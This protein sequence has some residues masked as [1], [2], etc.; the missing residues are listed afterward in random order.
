[1]DLVAATA[2]TYPTIPPS[3]A[4]SAFTVKGVEATFN[5]FL[6]HK[7]A[8]GALQLVDRFSSILAMLSMREEAL[9]KTILAVGLTTLGKGPNDQ[10]L[11]RQGQALYGKALQELGLALKN[12]KRRNSEALLATTGL[13]GL[14]EILYP[15]DEQSLTQARNWMSHAQGQLALIIERG[16]EAYT[17][18]VAHHLFSLARYNTASLSTHQ[19]RFILANIMAGFY[20]GSDS[21]ANGVQRGTV[22][23]NP[24][25]WKSQASKRHHR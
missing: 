12:P 14:Y 6:S 17:T 19:L 13:M 16:P 4:R 24:M 18:D 15:A 11:L 21:K 7:D 2:P 10:A 20:R 9:S 8:G 22:E 3:L 1:M 5:M 25:A 23:D